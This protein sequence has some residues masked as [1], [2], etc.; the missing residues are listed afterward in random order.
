M[1]IGERLAGVDPRKAL[2]RPQLSSDARSS[3]GLS[4]QALSSKGLSSVWM[5][6]WRPA[7]PVLLL[8]AL[9]VGAVFGLTYLG[10]VGLDREAATTSLDEV[11]TQL[12]DRTRTLESISRDYAWWDEAVQNLST[13]FSLG[14]ARDNLGR[15]TLS[16]SYKQITGSLV[17]DAQNRIAFGYLGD[18]ELNP[19]AA[20]VFAGGLEQLAAAARGNAGKP[21]TPVHGFLR[22]GDKI[23]LAGAAAVTPFN[24]PVP[25]LGAAARPVLVIL[26]VLDTETLTD[27]CMATRVAGLHSTDA[28]A[29]GEIGQAMTGPDGTPLGYLA[30][31]PPRPGRQLIDRLLLPILVVTALLAALC[32]VALDQL[33]RARRSAVSYAELVAAKND[34]LEQAA[35]LLSVTVDSIDEGI[36]VMRDDGGIRHWNETYERMWNFP[37][38]MRNRSNGNSA[39][40]ATPWSTRIRAWRIRPS[41]SSAANRCAAGC[42]ATPMAG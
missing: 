7:L 1:H 35:G 5:K 19:S 36:V 39:T 8:F 13:G 4:S 11:G 30:W 23:Y 15:S 32:V 3:Q 22:L 34:S 41:P 26:S 31:Q 24:R 18:H 25:A 28:L 40:A 10:G 12:A 42:T 21:P 16:G 29:P 17:L 38:G 6:R 20:V 9:G 27:I 2:P 33:L 14:W 37:P